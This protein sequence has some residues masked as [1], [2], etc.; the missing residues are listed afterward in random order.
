MPAA[1]RPVVPSAAEA[2]LWGIFGC[3][4][5]PGVLLATGKEV[6][7]AAFAAGGLAVIVLAAYVAL[8]VWGAKLSD[9]HEGDGVG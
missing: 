8:R 5:V 9:I 3:L 7:V 1:P 2:A 4:L 6:E